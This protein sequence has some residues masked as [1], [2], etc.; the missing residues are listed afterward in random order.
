MSEMKKVA[1]MGPEEESKVFS[2]LEEKQEL[3]P[4]TKSTNDSVKKTDPKKSLAARS[5]IIAGQVMAEPSLQERG[6]GSVQSIEDQVMVP[7]HDEGPEFAQ[8]HNESEEQKH[9]EKSVTVYDNE[10]RVF[11][12]DS[13]NYDNYDPFIIGIRFWRAHTVGWISA[14]NEFLKAW[15][16]NIKLT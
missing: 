4:S 1:E 10:S 13:P 7:K 3:N 15:V 5:D 16:D 12:S 6:Y 2:H 14:Y 9:L 11:Y 8:I